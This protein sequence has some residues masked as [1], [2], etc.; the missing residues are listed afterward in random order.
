MKQKEGVAQGRNGVAMVALGTKVPKYPT[1]PYLSCWRL[2]VEWFEE[3]RRSWKPTAGS[4]RCFDVFCCLYWS[5]LIS[6]LFLSPFQ[7]IAKASC[8]F[9]D[10]HSSFATSACVCWVPLHFLILFLRFPAFLPIP[11]LTS[12]F[13]CAF[14]FCWFST[15]N[16]VTTSYVPRRGVKL[17]HRYMPENHC[18]LHTWTITWQANYIM[19]ET[20]GSFLH[21]FTRVNELLCAPGWKEDK[22]TR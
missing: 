9:S 17:Q 18:S 3:S 7:R 4:C 13:L 15:N 16:G 2:V 8:P 22:S 11:N 14:P 21:I 10:G 19:F 5:L 20:Y 6:F 1:S 12:P